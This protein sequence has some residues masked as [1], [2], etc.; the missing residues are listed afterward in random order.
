MSTNL[1]IVRSGDDRYGGISRGA[2]SAQTLTLSDV[3][4][5]RERARN[6]QAVSPYISVNAQIVNANNNWSTQVVGVSADFLVIRDWG[7]SQGAFFTA[8]DSQNRA[9][10][11]VIG[12]TIRDNVFPDQDPIGQ[13]IRVNSTPFKVIG[14]LETKGQSAMGSDQDDTIFAPAET[15]AFRMKGD[16]YVQRM[17][18]SANT[19]EEVPAAQAEITELLRQIHRLKD[20]A[21]DDFSLRTQT[22]INDMASATTETLTLLL[23]AI[24][25]VSLL[26]G[27]IGIMNIMLVSVTERTREIGIRI[28]IGARGVDVMSQ[29]LVEAIVLSILGG[30]LGVAFSGALCFALMKVWNIPAVMSTPVI[31]LSLAVSGGIGIFFGMYPARKAANLDPIEALRR[32]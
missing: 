27:G 6:L 1:I 28:A 3:E 21:P 10:V 7:L 9:K 29:F 2:G 5:V 24:A 32:E 23:G 13:T 16:H 20:G 8:K 11:A 19:Q 31:L 14:V 26:V 17:Y 15:V 22:E 25:G 18:V 4:Q 12:S 30:L